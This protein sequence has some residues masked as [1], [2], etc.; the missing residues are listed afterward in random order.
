[1]HCIIPIIITVYRKIQLNIIHYNVLCPGYYTERF[2]VVYG[3]V[4]NGPFSLIL[5]HSFDDNIK[6]GKLGK[7][8]LDRIGR[9]LK[10]YK[11]PLLLFHAEG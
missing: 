3:E 10:T 9:I 7:D 2:T 4:S 6:L 1:M 8:S 11:I 5:K